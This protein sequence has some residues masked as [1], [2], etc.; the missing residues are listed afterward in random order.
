MKTETQKM[1]RHRQVLFCAV[2]VMMALLAAPCGGS[3]VGN[4]SPV[5]LD[6][7]VTTDQDTPVAATLEATDADG[8][9]LSYEAVTEPTNGLLSGTAPDLIYTPDSNFT[10]DDSFTFNANDGSTDSNT[11]TVSITVNPVVPPVINPPVINPPVVNNAPEATDASVNAD[12][13]V[14]VNFTLSATDA[15]GD[16]LSYGRET[17]PSHGTLTGTAPALTYTPDRNYHGSDSFTFKANDGSVDSN[18][19]TITITID[20]RPEIS[21]NNGYALAIKTDGTLWAWGYNYEGQLGL[22]DTTNEHTPVLVDADTNWTAVAGY[23]SH[24][25]ALKTDGTL[26]AWGDNSSGQLGDGTTTPRTSPVPVGADNDW[27]AIAAGYEHSLALKTDGT[28]WAWG[29]NDYGQLGLG[30]EDSDPHPTPEQVVGISDVVAIAAG[31]NHNLAIKTDGTLY[32]WGNN[33]YGQLA[34]D[35][36]DANPHPT[37]VQVG[38]DTDWDAIAGGGYYNLALKADGTL[39]AWGDN[40]DGQ[41]GLGDTTDRTSPVQVDGSW[42]TIATGYEHSL[43]LKTDGTLW[44]W[45]DNT[46]GQLGDG[47]LTDRPSPVQVCADYNVLSN[48]CTTPL[49]D[50]VAVT[51][52]SRHSL[53]LKANGTLWAWGGN[54]DGGLGIS[55]FP[56]KFSPVQVV[57]YNDVSGYLTDVVALATGSGGGHSLALKADGTLWA[58]GGNYFGQLGLGDTEARPIPLKVGA[59]T[60]WGTIAAGYHHTLGVKAGALYAWGRN[61]FGQLAVNPADTGPHP[62]PVQVGL[63]IDWAAVAGGQSHSLAVRDDGIDKTLWAWGKN[64]YGKLGIGNIVSPQT[65]PQQEVLGATDW[66]VVAGGGLHSLAIKADVDNTL[67]AWGSNSVGRLG[68]GTADLD[69]HHTPVQVCEVY[70]AG[71]TTP[72]TGVAAVAAGHGH[73]LGLKINGTLWAWGSNAY[74]QLG[75]GDTINNHFTPEQVGALDTWTAIAA[76][77][78]HSLAIRDDGINKTLWAWGRNNYGQLGIGTVDTDPHHTPVQVGTDNDWA[79]VAA[80]IYHSLALKTDGTVWAW[81]RNEGGGLGDGTAWTTTP[82]EVINWP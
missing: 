67:W 12:E 32:A 16:T 56:D 80:G 36:A 35:P 31:Y 76:G 46:D 54:A 41:L 11:A 28:L 29:Y 52:G 60:D 75:L 25:L 62:N 47:T 14:P 6:D 13:D 59:D 2:T 71:C 65:T 44:A 82:V 21:A 27:V 15:D 49:T 8:D 63:D 78:E 73:S 48:N 38:T 58:W 30:T 7:S 61:N 77:Y 4:T 81:G 50:V 23:E 43:A 45:G 22:G 9:T 17:L 39:W 1:P 57:D 53:A 33:E 20:V 34:I 18:V 64:D 5:A 55:A 68:I 40:S 79:D 66:A 10:G 72:F 70:A 3:G 51:S 69:P 42:T 74:G 37:P 26:W 24:S 19:A